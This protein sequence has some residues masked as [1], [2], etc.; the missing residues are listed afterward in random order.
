MRILL[1]LHQRGI[2]SGNHLN[3]SA[4]NFSKT[5]MWRRTL[6]MLTIDIFTSSLS[7]IDLSQKSI[8][9]EKTDHKY[10]SLTVFLIHL[11]I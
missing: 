2:S 9:K 10:S 5:W 6:A 3:A 8:Y 7:N 11:L 1:H 4:L